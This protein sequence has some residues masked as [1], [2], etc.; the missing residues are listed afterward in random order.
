MR[1]IKKPDFFIVGA[2]KCGT[3]AMDR[4]LSAHPD[5]FMARKEMHHFGA[6]LK[7]GPHF[8]RRNRDEYLAEFEHASGQSRLGESSVW[9]L[10]SETAATEFKSFNP[11]ARIIIMLRDPVE[12]LHSLYYTFR[13]DNNEVLPT[14]EEALAAEDERRAGRKLGRATYLAQGLVYSDVVLYAR[15]VERYFNVFGRNRVHVILY[16]DFKKNVPETYRKTLEFLGVNP[17]AAPKNFE[18]INDNKYTRFGA[19]RSVMS[20]PRLRSTVL[21]VR[22][23]V[24]KF[25]FSAMQKTDAAVRRFNSSVGRRPEL[26][27]ELCGKLS[28]KFAP[29][30]ERLGLL[31]R[32]D[33]SHWSGGTVRKQAVTTATAKLPLMAAT[34]TDLRLVPRVPPGVATF[35]S[36]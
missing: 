35:K 36:R 24:P 21:A 30:M 32:R 23:W 13:W 5:I 12:M 31:L 33:L 2:P 28:R 8:F 19:L 10:F 15:Q 14:F 22:P 20:D 6:D 3:T 17:A 4:Y 26:N 18:V 25:V 27:P 9:C 34:G 11:D 16:D 29:E 7:F 1:M